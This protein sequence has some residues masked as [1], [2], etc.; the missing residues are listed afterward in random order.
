MW[1]TKL[2]P[3]RTHPVTTLPTVP[4]VL[5]E[6]VPLVLLL[7]FSIRYLLFREMSRATARLLSR[8]LVVETPLASAPKPALS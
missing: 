4:R 1:S 2:C 6:M 8:T 5:F 3:P 7:K